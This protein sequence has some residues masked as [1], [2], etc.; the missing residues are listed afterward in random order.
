MI[1]ESYNLI[2]ARIITYV[3]KY[4]WKKHVNMTDEHFERFCK[5]HQLVN[6]F[7]L[8]ESWENIEEYLEVGQKKGASIVFIMTNWQGATFKKEIDITSVP[9][10]SS[11]IKRRSNLYFDNWME[12]L[13][14]YLFVYFVIPLYYI[15]L[16]MRYVLLFPEK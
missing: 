11:L 16:L 15:Y 7:S 3:D 4:R 13:D 10:T 9:P 14:W 6:Q 8:K 12:R 2:V 1:N 5:Q